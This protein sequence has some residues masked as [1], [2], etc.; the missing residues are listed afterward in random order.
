MVRVRHSAN[1]YFTVEATEIAAM[2]TIL[3]LCLFDTTMGSVA[4][5]TL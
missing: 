2:S 3:L 1:V 5:I 4:I